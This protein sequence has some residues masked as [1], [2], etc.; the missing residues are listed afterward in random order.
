MTRSYDEINEKIRKGKAV[1]LTAEEVSEMAKTMTPKEILEKVD[2]VT[3]A[4]FGAMCSSGALLNFGHSTPPIRMERIEINGVPVTGGL[5]AVDTFVGATDCNM[6]NPTYGGAHIIQDL[7]DGKE[8]MLEAWGKGTDCYPRK[9][10]K[11]MISL[12]T[13][14]EA[15]LMNPRNAYQNYNV[16][17][18]SSDNTIYTY[19]GTLLPHMRNASYSSAGELSPLLNDPECRTIGLGTRIFLAGAVGYVIW[20]GTQ[21]NCSKPLNS[22]GVPMGNARTLALMGEMREMSSEFLRGAYFEKYGV[23]LYVGVG[24]PIPLLDE[25][26]AA[27]VSIRNNQIDTFIKDYGH[28]GDIIGKVNY[29]Q[30]RSGQIEFMDKKIHTAPMS[31]LYKARRIAAILK[32]W[33]GNGSFEL[34]A[35]VRPMPTG[36]TLNDL[37]EIYNQQ[38]D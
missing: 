6:Q 28:N 4:T 11:T 24:I 36:R 13:I 32:E 33:I 31:S 38:N 34:S 29:E 8:L 7:I 12:E 2:V 22:H 18:N 30:L 26:L 10:I 3:T 17:I 23:S 1:V 20:N 14:N 27:R 25:D 15:I 9:H 35:P 16:A 5:A 21:F 37:K 19:M